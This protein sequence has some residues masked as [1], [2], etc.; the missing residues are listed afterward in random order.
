[1]KAAKYEEE[2]KSQTQLK[3]TEDTMQHFLAPDPVR[4][5]KPKPKSQ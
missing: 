3:R 1:M 4:R 2:E 5:H